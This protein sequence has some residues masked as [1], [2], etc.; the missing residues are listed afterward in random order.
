MNVFGQREPR[1]EEEGVEKEVEWKEPLSQNDYGI[2]PP[3]KEL[4]LHLVSD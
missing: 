2:F 1:G 3:M 4:A